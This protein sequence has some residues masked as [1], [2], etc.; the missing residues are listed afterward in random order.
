MSK[1]LIVYYSRTGHTQK[2]ARAVARKFDGD[3]EQLHEFEHQGLWFGAFA[4][5]LKQKTRLKRT[6]YGPQDYDLVILGT[7]VWAGSLPPAMRSY[8]SEQ[9]SNFLKAA[10][11]CT[12]GGSGG[13]RVFRQMEKLCGKSP[14]ATLEI[15]ETE[16]KSGADS[17]KIEKFADTIGGFF[18]DLQFGRSR[19]S[20][21]EVKS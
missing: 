20:A 15:T 8:I 5:L 1:F 19:R 6:L 16:L 7:P 13:R 17:G 11:F 21:E 14:L 2:V 3:L 12:E 18:K 10:F 9:S 4:A